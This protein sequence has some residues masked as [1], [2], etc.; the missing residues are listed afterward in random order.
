MTSGGELTSGGES[1]S[2][3]FGCTRYRAEELKVG[4]VAIEIWPAF[5]RTATASRMPRVEA[6]HSLARVAWDGQAIPQSSALSARRTRTRR[7]RVDKPP[8][9]Q[10]RSRMEF[11]R[12]PR[13]PEVATCQPMTDAEVAAASPPASAFA[14]LDAPGRSRSRGKAPI[15]GRRLDAMPTRGGTSSHLTPDVLRRGNP[16]QSHLACERVEVS[17]GL[18]EVSAEDSTQPGRIHCEA[19]D[20]PTGASAHAAR[21]TA[22]T[23][24]APPT[25]RSQFRT[26]SAE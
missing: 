8:T 20:E 4:A 22:R 9:F 17:A 14:G 18:P 23:H 24:R 25:R 13:A 10:D 7:S 1:G 21:R 19:V 16:S 3:A 6:E 12:P 15:P 5:M 11:N 26:S 2:G